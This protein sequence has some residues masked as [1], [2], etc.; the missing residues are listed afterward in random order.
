MINSKGFNHIKLCISF[1]ECF[2][3]MI[4]LIDIFTNILY[5]D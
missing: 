4:H 5:Y 3:Q 2:H 1:F